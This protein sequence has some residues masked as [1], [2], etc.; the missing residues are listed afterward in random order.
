MAIPVRRPARDEHKTAR[1]RYRMD[2]DRGGASIADA[3]HAVRAL[4]AR[5]GHHP[6]H[7]PS[8]DAQLVVSEMVTNAIRHAPGP[9]ALLLELTSDATRLRIAVRDSS[10]H[11]PVVH[12]PDAH[13]IGGHGLYLVSR[14][15]GR[16]HTM[17][18]GVGKQVTAHLGLATPLRVPGVGCI[19]EGDAGLLPDDICSP[20]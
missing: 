18:L 6:D 3:R 16:I 5:A 8:Q 4:L 17:A 19:G 10:P 20:G 12:E 2:W 15:C 1:L 9:G 14:L 11:P 7:R 13:R